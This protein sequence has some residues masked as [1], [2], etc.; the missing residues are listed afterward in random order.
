MADPPT[1]E[2]ISSANMAAA[3]ST[4]EATECT[5]ATTDATLD[6]ALD[7][8]ELTLTPQAL[9]RLSAATSA[10]SLTDHKAEPT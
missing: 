1:D 7:L 9:V 8:T 3:M 5:S 6:E 4:I 10:M 2:H